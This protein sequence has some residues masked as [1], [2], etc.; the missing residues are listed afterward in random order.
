MDRK[1]ST[2]LEAFRQLKVEIRGS[3]EYLIVGIDVAKDNHRAFFGTATGKAL[4]RRLVFEN[5]IEGF[6]KLLVHEEALRARHALSKT[7][8]GLEPTADYH[9]PLA[10]FLINRGHMVVLVGGRP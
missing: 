4:L 1:E 2:R 8:F 10:Q 5:S 9:K 7:V 6:G 3:G